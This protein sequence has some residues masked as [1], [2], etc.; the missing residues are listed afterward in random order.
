MTTRLLIDLVG[1]TAAVL[2]TLCWLPQAIKVLREKETRAISLP[3]MATL[4][5]G[6]SLWLAYGL[7]IGDWPLIGANGITLA[8]MVPILVMK[9]RYG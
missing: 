5:T 4:M 6:V 1:L 2:T 3:A 7:A 8:L 9:L